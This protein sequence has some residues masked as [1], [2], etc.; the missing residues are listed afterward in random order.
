MAKY[1]VAWLPGD[2]VGKE[3]MEAARFCLDALK[4]DAEYPHG[5]IG[6]EFWINEGNPL[7]DR[8]KK[9]PHET[10]CALFGAITSK[11]ME[12]AAKELKPL[13]ISNYAYDLAK[14]FNNFYTHCPVLSAEDE[15]RSA[16]LRLV[17]A[18]KQTIINSLGLL[19]IA[20]PELM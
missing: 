19:G 7:P 6:W 8:T 16:R 4:L 2:G 15:V 18:A 13:Q 14:A 5:D 12:E 17:A 9:L 10:N 3:V 20:T 1:R 11:P